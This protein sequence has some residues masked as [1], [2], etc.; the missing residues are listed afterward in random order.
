MKHT[1]LAFHQL[2]AAAVFGII[3][4]TAMAQSPAEK[5]QQEFEKLQA[6]SQSIP[7]PE[8]V[9]RKPDSDLDTLEKL[10]GLREH[11]QRVRGEFAANIKQGQQPFHNLGLTCD[12]V[13]QKLQEFETAA[14]KY[15]S[16]AGIQ[17]D[18]DHVVRMAKQSIQY[19]AP[20]YFKP[21]NDIDL[22][23]QS[24]RQRIRYLAAIAPN[25]PELKNAMRLTEDA[26]K[27][28]REIQKGLEKGILEQNELPP[29][30]YAQGDRDVLIQRLKE[31]WAKEGTKAAVLKVGIVGTEWNRRVS[32]EIQNRT[33]YK[34]DQSRIQGYVV[35]ALDS[36][37]AVR[38]SINLTKDH[39]SNDQ[40]SA[41]FVGD[42]K[43][44][45][46]LINQLLVTKI[47]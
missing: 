18:L 7:A 5:A 6:V 33:L 45:P 9:G 17:E 3:A 16:Q 38:H 20:A 11:L 32:W 22:R 2:F 14:K 34:I 4:M 15:A 39:L 42:P 8:Y 44:E 30:Q 1:S 10:T 40:I 31:K 25:S 21:G 27:Q 47:K 26:A 12:L 36:Q 35:V 24:A 37:R 13:A 46:E 41:N 19:Q 23:T 29:D 43:A 28:V